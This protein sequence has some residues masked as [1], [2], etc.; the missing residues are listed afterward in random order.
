[1]RKPSVHELIVWLTTI[2]R[3]VHRPLLASTLFRFINLSSDI[4]LFGLA[5]WAV[6]QALAGQLRSA[7]MWWL[8]G[9]A[10]L[11]ALAY[12]LEQFLGHYVAFKALELL[13]GYAFSRLWPQA[14]MVQT[15][16]RSG[17]LLASLTR[18]VDRIEV[19]YAHTFAPVVSA[20]VV[21]PVFLLATGMTVGWSVVALAGFCY[22]LSITVVPML[23]A[24]GS[25]AT[26]SVQLG[27]RAELV[28]HV[29]DS[30][31]GVEEVVGYGLEKDRLQATDRLGGLV[32]QDA[33][34]P[35]T[36][37]GLRRGLNICLSAL[38]VIGVAYGGYSSGVDPALLFALC[39]GSLRL[40]EG[41]KGVEDAVGAL[42]ASFASARRIWE[43]AHRPLAIV[44]GHDA[45]PRGA[46]VSIEWSGVTYSYPG[47]P[48]DRPVLKDFSFVVPAGAHAT[49]VGR[50][51]SGKTT[52]AQLLLRFDD[53]SAGGIF[54][55]GVDVRSIRL[56]D[57]RA[58]VVMVAQKNQILDTTVMDNVRLGAPGASEADVWAALDV[59]CLADEVRAMPHGLLTRT[60]QDGAFLS[61]GQG[62]RLG[63]ARAVLM[64]PSV[65]ILD[66]FS[67]N[68][69]VE[70]ARKIR[71]N[72]AEKLAGVTIIDITHVEGHGSPDLTAKFGA[73]SAAS[74]G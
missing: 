34:G 64:R 39:A 43:I 49:F 67:A 5:G 1:M 7:H 4:F 50:S 68:L 47:C 31:F 41:P 46:G 9:V 2:T 26:T 16:S 60:G 10:L 54:L 15:T 40:F 59:A 8:V 30:V 70:L 20:L 27:H 25:F 52:A 66:E 37:R 21:P 19:V 13:R 72:I 28:S 53:P 42:D 62:Q 51:G 44:D 65:L 55:N 22:L 61:G 56:D 18:D 36:F 35:A 32:A 23:G 69:N 3:P 6:M 73:E 12:Y 74:A 63:L 38:A 71:E 58:N 11:K 48:Q 17:D 14:P 24:R 33:S 45:F 29:T 57:V